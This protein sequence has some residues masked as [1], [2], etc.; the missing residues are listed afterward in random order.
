MISDVPILHAASRS[1]YTHPARLEYDKF[2]AYAD[3][4]LCHLSFS[5]PEVQAHEVQGVDIFECLN[6]LRRILQDEYG[7]YLSCAGSRIDTYSSGA[8]RNMSGGRV[9]FIYTLGQYP[10]RSNEVRIFDP[11]PPEK[12]GSLE[13]QQRYHDDWLKSINLIS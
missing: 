12:V 2:I 3:D 6:K 1:L 11:A 10:T 9:L 13:E 8:A 5:H 7:L 4:S